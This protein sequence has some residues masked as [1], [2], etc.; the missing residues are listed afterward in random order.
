MSKTSKTTQ[1]NKPPAWAQPLFSTSA[2]DAM[3][4][5]KSGSGGNTYTGSTVA[6][7]SGTT[8]GG[9][10][11]LANAGQAWDTSGTRPL[12]QGLGASA[13]SN[14]A[15]NRLFNAANDAGGVGGQFSDI[16][17]RAGA[18]SSAQSNLSGYASGQYLDPANNPYFSKALQNQLDNT[19]STVQSQFSGMGRYGSGADTGELTRQLGQL[20]TSAMSDQ[21]N[22]EQQNQFAANQQ[23]DAARQCR[24][25]GTQLR[26]RRQGQLGS[27]VGEQGNMLANAGQLY[28]TGIGQGLHRQPTMWRNLDQRNFQNQL[29]GAG[30]TLAGG[31]LARSAGSE[32]AQRRS[33]QVVLA[34]QSGLDE[35]RHVAE[36]GG[37]RGRAVRNAGCDLAAACRRRRHSRRARLAFR[38]QIDA[39]HDEKGGG[40]TTMPRQPDELGTAWNALQG[41]TQP[42]TAAG[43]CRQATPRVAVPRTCP[44]PAWGRAV[45]RAGSPRCS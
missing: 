17:G 37:R 42:A 15:T 19:A 6:P 40:S 27:G 31:R 20:S 38:R 29:T 45:H 8:M 9:V 34:R 12:Y 44:P 1:E 32:A 23:I 4:L 43:A 33:R 41:M 25:F 14:P 18:P 22:R 35:A 13:V 36:R 16:Y 3:N 24:H 11:Q 5:Y 7:L 21:F 26:A 28:S 30:A 2:T 10:N 39:R